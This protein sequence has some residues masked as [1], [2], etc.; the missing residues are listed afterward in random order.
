MQQKILRERADTFR[1]RRGTAVVLL[2]ILFVSLAAALCVI[3]E[4]SDRKAAVSMA[5][6]AF[7][8]A[9]RSVLSAYDK[10][11]QER[12]GL[13]AIEESEESVGKRV[14]SLAGSSLEHSVMA[15]SYV[16]SVDIEET[17]YSLGSPDNLMMQISAMSE[18]LALTE[19]LRGLEDEF[20]TAGDRIEEQES[21]EDLLK[22]LE[23]EK[24]E[25]KKMLRDQAAA[26]ESEE[27]VDGESTGLSAQETERQIQNADKVQ[28]QLKEQKKQYSADPEISSS[29]RTLRNG[30]VS[31]SLPSVSAGCKNRFAFSGAGKLRDLRRN[32][33]GASSRDALFR[34]VYIEHYFGNA[35]SEDG[36]STFFHNETEY[37]LYGAMA[38][39]E[40]YK[41]AYRAIFAIR[42]AV[43][44]AYL[45]TDAEKRNAV[46]AAAEALT[47]GAFAPL[48]QLLI[49]TAWSAAEARNDMQNLLHFKGVPVSKSSGTWMI[50]LDSVV[51]GSLQDGYIEIPGSSRM[52]YDRY[53]DLLLMTLDSETQLYRI[54]DL[55]QINMKGAVR[56]DF[57]IADH[58]TGFEL[59]ASIRKESHAAGIPDSS[60]TIRMTHTYLKEEP[61]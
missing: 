56:S 14:K 1:R 34:L 28:N 2:S 48:T 5:E 13:F 61:S 23:Q 22:R 29:G 54:M 20:H 11:L 27:G 25:A 32:G 43:N 59:S 21:T 47:P 4:A 49:M 19:S 12:Y 24:E 31:D 53:L 60:S 36:D 51:N 26:A 37:I 45:Y 15:K 46:L 10:E 50:D 7:E 52:T 18:S 30:H 58:M 3:Y 41:K 8:L 17:A 38:D 6:S 33:L 44:T 16:D 40:N 57:T 42:T 39:E 55:I 9:G 35:L